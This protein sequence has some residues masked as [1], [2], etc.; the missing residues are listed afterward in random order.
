MHGFT[1]VLRSGVEPTHSALCLDKNEAAVGK[2]HTNVVDGKASLATY[3][4]DS[5]LRTQ[6]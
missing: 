5:D 1:E 6:A 2:G 3:S 4:F